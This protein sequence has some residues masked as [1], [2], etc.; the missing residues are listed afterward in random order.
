MIETFNA[1]TSLY[2]SGISQLNQFIQYRSSQFSPA[3]P[4]SEI[5]E[6]KSSRNLLFR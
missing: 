3:K 4:D 6:M 2:N 5:L 1:T